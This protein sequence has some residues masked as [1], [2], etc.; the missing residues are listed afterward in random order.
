MGAALLLEREA[1]RRRVQPRRRRAAAPQALP[2]HLRQ[3]VAKGGGDGEEGADDEDVP[4]ERGRLARAQID[5]LVIL[6]LDEAVARLVGAQLGHPV[7]EQ[8]AR[9]AHGKRLLQREPDLP[10]A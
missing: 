2:V 9:L 4:V 8:V 7:E 6:G 1:V 3:H 5:A 10:L